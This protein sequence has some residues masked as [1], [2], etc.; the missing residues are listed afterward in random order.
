MVAGAV[1]HRAVEVRKEVGGR[2]AAIHLPDSPVRRGDA[3]F[4]KEL[5]EHGDRSVRSLS[6]RGLPE[7]VAL[8]FLPHAAVDQF[9]PEPAYRA[10]AMDIRVG[11]PVS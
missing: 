5:P 7:L 10:G 4:V 6:P 1:Q 8:E 9:P 3:K 11:T 2:G